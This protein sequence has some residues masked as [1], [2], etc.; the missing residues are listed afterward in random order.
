[1]AAPPAQA[2]RLFGLS[3]LDERAALSSNAITPH[4]QALTGLI[5]MQITV[6]PHVTVNFSGAWWG[7]GPLS[8][9]RSESPVP[10]NGFNDLG[11]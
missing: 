10:Q 9:Y 11:L 4:T 8:S 6:N 3:L 1:M 2:T 7:G 5:Y